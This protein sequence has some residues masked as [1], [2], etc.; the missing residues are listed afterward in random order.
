[1]FQQ[2]APILFVHEIDANHVEKFVR[3]TGT[4]TFVDP[5]IEYCELE[6]KGHFIVVDITAVGT[7]WK[8]GETYQCFGKIFSLNMF[9]KVRLN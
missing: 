3:I 2:H 4:L 7:S 8:L 9:P 6:H 5:V 1:M